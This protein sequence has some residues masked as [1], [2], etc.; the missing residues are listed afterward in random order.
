MVV[1]AI[2]AAVVAY[3]WFTSVQGSL[4]AKASQRLSSVSSITF[5]IP[6]VKCEENNVVSFIIMNLS[7]EDIP[8]TNAV[9]AL[10]DA[11]GKVLEVNYQVSIGPVP[12]HG[13]E[14]YT[15]YFPHH[16]CNA[17]DVK[18]FMLTIGS[19]SVTRAFK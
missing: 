8:E 13:T 2:T 6:A 7:D 16:E 18:A 17:S 4:Q 14:E 19:A 1:I 10:L 12:A 11:Q 9:A 3:S 15:A 5:T